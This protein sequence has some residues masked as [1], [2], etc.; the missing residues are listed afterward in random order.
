MRRKRLL[1]SVGLICGFVL[2][3]LLGLVVMVKREPNFYA[4]A[5]VPAGPAR[6]SASNAAIGQ[7]TKLNSSLITY[8]PRWE[9]QFTT[10]QV[11]AYF[12]EDFQRHGG[13]ENLP[14][15][16][17][18]PRVKIEDDKIRI[19]VRYGEG[20]FSTII[21]LELKLWKIPNESNVLALEIV[22]LQAGSLPLSTGTLLDSIS[23]AARREKIDITWYR[24]QGHPVGIMRFQSDMTRPT[25]QFESVETKD[26]KLTIVG[27]S[28]DLGAA[29]LLPG[30]PP[31]VV[32]PKK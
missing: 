10:D 18:A 29:P 7:F 19:G 5:T 6:V 25:F 31:R 11:N 26:G 20:L 22:S 3:V 21:T 24:H 14:E 1:I 8:E 17:H 16:C 13:D 15:G 2:L 30:P 32:T 4:Q 12:Q 28:T 9:I 23:E 27:R